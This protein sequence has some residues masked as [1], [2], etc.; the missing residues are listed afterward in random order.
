MY[1]TFNMGVGLVAAVAK[2]DVDKRYL[3]LRK[4]AKLPISSVKPCRVNAALP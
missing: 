2:T 4:L 3:L 1:N